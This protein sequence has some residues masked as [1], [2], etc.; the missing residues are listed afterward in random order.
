M[1]EIEK[2]ISQNGQK[3]AMTSEEKMAIKNRLVFEIG[4]SVQTKSPYLSAFFFMERHVL[5]TAFAV[6]L[7]MSGT[8]SAFAER[9]L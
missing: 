6:V 7:F 4:K 8:V 5:G 9:A 1:N 2:F 3:V